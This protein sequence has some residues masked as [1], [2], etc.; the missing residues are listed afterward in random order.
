MADE[1][2]VEF[3]KRS[4]SAWN[5][6]RKEV[7]HGGDPRRRRPDL[8]G[9]NLSGAS[10]AGANL[11]DANLHGAN[12]R[13]ADLAGADLSRATLCSANLGPGKGGAV[14]ALRSGVSGSIVGEAGGR[15]ADLANTALWNADL[16]DADLRGS[17]NLVPVQLEHAFGDERTILPDGFG[18]PAHWMNLAE[19]DESPIVEAGTDATANN[20]SSSVEPPPDTVRDGASSAGGETAGLGGPPYTAIGRYITGGL[21]TGAAEPSTDAAPR[22]RAA[23]IELV[24]TDPDGS[25]VFVLA[26]RD[27]VASARTEA[28]RFDNLAPDEA[29]EIR[30]YLDQLDAAFADLVDIIDRL[31]T[32]KAGLEDDLERARVRIAELESNTSWRRIHESFDKTLGATAAAGLCAAIG[33]GINLLASD[34]V[35]EAMELFKRIMA[36]LTPPK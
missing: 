30:S 23:V 7:I 29:R 26:L 10:L 36:A 13:G 4:V 31:K 32:E 21:G 27:Y 33:A 6:W 12:L 16:R 9:A 17:R 1:E 18:H 22:R 14:A 25:R 19:P 15:R 35:P 8:S 5:E 3:L 28:D 11:S 34:A 24:E 20:G 2:L